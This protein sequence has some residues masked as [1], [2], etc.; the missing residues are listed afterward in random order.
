MEETTI[1][2]ATD[3]R[4]WLDS[5]RYDVRSECG[6]D[7]VVRAV[8]AI[9]ADDHPAWGADWTDYLES[10]H[11]RSIVDSAALSAPAWSFDGYW[12]VVVGANRNASDAV[13]EF[14]LAPGDDSGF[15]EWLS[16]AESIAWTAG[17]HSGEPVPEEWTEYHDR[18]VRLLADAA[19]SK[20]A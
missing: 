15:S 18:A 17:G 10:D 19:N 13:R 14:D 4:N 9:R 12:N 3:I 16:E 11:V 20:G 6:A 5:S 2:T 8:E 1:T 7:A